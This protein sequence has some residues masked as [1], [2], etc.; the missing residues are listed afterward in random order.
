MPKAS[1]AELDTYDKSYKKFDAFM[2]QLFLLFSSKP[3]V[4][5]NDQMKIIMALSFMK[6]GFASTWATNITRW[7]R[8]GGLTF[9]G[10]ASFE[11]KLKEVFDDLN[12]KRAAQDYAKKY[13]RNKRAN[14]RSDGEVTGR[15][16]IGEGWA[17]PGWIRMGG[18]P[19]MGQ[20]SGNP[21]TGMGTTGTNPNMG[22]QMGMGTNIGGGHTFP[23]WGKPMDIDRQQ[24]W[25]G[26]LK[27]YNCNC[28]ELGHISRNCSKPR[29]WNAMRVVFEGLTKEQKG[30]VAEIFNL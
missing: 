11:R 17:G 13:D 8:E 19:G 20:G 12:K 21:G 30:E 22:G 10:W 27:C 2:S 7:L 16:R 3:S 1:I 23:G 29:G 5:A 4:Y 28:G 26:L 18:L 25:V 14:E 24:G 9:S 6:K 15:R